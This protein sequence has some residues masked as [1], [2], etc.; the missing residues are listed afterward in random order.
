MSGCI[1]EMELIQSV[2][3][4]SDKDANWNGVFTKFLFDNDEHKIATNPSDN[5]L[6]QYKN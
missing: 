5:F 3:L 1:C 4:C 2:M 6:K